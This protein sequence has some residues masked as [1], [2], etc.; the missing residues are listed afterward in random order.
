M[1]CVR[2]D[3]MPETTTIQETMAGTARVLGLAPEEMPTPP[4]TALGRPL[5]VAETAGTVAFLLSD[6][7]S[8]T[9]AQVVD[10]GG[11]VLPG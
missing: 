1:N 8:A 2:G 10:V 11:Q 3:A 6:L 4:R 9:T 5:T 7:A